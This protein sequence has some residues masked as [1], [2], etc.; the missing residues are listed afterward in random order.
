MPPIY[1][2]KHLNKTIKTKSAEKTT[3]LFISIRNNQ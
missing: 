2:Q 3:A 1:K